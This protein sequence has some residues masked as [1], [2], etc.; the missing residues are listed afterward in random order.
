M[1]IFT[2]IKSLYVFSNTC[3]ISVLQWRRSPNYEHDLG[4]QG[5]I[6]LSWPLKKREK[7]AHEL[8]ILKFLMKNNFNSVSLCGTTWTFSMSVRAVASNKN[9]LALDIN[10]TKKLTVFYFFWQMQTWC[11]VFSVIICFAVFRNP[12]TN[13][14]ATFNFFFS[15]LV[16][17]G[18]F[19]SAFILWHRCWMQMS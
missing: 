11:L 1:I 14:E 12:Q 9:C 18:F 10:S 4:K 7:L 15:C 3:G 17:V 19:P 5:N 6:H 2:L 8:R 16:S 13:K